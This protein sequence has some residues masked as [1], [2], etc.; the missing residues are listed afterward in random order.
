MSESR[1]A[2]AYLEARGV[3]DLS[4]NFSGKVF[5]STRNA[6]AN[7]LTGF[8]PGM[9]IGDL[10]EQVKRHSLALE[11]WDEFAE[12][13]DGYAGRRQSEF[14]DSMELCPTTSETKGLVCIPFH[15]ALG[16]SDGL[17]VERM[18][19]ISCS[20]TSFRS[21]TGDSSVRPAPYSSGR[22]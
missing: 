4:P 18:W 2:L 7:L 9:P 16:N 20:G 5:L 3:R 22:A 12:H 1:E 6:S 17:L 10:V 13:I 8:A 14:A 19:R 15:I 11:V 21:W